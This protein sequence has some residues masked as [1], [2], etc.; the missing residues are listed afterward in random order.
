[1]AGTPFVSQGEVLLVPCSPTTACGA[2]RIQP[3]AVVTPEKGK[4]LLAKAIPQADAASSGDAFVLVSP[5]PES[6]TPAVAPK[7]APAPRAMSITMRAPYTVKQGDTLVKIARAYATTPDELSKLNP[8]LT[9]SQPLVAN[10]RMIVPHA[11]AH[12]YLDQQ[13]L[14]G[15]PVPYVVQG[16]AMVPFRKIVEAKHGMVIWIPKTHEVNAWIDQTFMGFT[17]DSRAARLNGE[18]Y[19]LPVAAQLQGSRAM[20]PLRYIAAALRLQ[21]EYNAETGAYYLISRATPPAE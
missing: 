4:V 2:T 1:M 12:L 7:T 14:I 13:P 3:S 17:I 5:A 11:S 21:I 15:A 8:D 18:E 20:V 19:L 10:T 6:V 9:P 16:Y